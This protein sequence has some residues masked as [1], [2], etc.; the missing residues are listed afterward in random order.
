MNE[1]LNVGLFEIRKVGCR[2]NA[3]VFLLVKK[4]AILNNKFIAW[5]ADPFYPHPAISYVGPNLRPLSQA[6]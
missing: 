3:R 2:C 6:L 1:K 5:A 4:L